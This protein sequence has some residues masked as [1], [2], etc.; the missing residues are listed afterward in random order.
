MAEK[1]SI[2][3]GLVAVAIYSLGYLQKKRKAII[4][5]NFTSR[6][7]YIIQYLLLGAFEGAALDIAGAVSSVL[8]ERKDTKFLKKY[9][10]PVLLLMDLAMVAIGLWL[11]EN[12]YSLL[13][14]IGVLLHTSAF[15]MNDE[16][17]IRIVSLIGSPFWLVYNW[18]SG[19]KPSCI[20]DVLSMIAMITAMIRYD[21]NWSKNKKVLDKQA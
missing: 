13:P 7:L 1:I 15:W 11:Y 19:A 5:M 16:K 18:V 12:P 17:K 21:F 8:A 6:V 3:I 2:M 14:L 4:L 20:G 9:A 10:L